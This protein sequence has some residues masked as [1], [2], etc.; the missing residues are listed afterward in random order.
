MVLN[1]A[2]VSLPI[3]VEGEAVSTTVV[4]CFVFVETFLS[5]RNTFDTGRL[6]FSIAFMN[7]YIG[8]ELGASAI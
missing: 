6:T 3:M 1:I 5:S 2:K 8:V 7:S 4:V